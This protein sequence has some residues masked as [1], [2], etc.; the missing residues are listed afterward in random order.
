[1]RNNLGNPIVG[2]FKGPGKTK[3]AHAIKFTRPVVAQYITL[4]IMK[5]S[6]I[7]Q[8]NGIKV[9]EISKMPAVKTGLCHRALKAVNRKMKGVFIPRCNK[10]GSYQKKQ[11]H[12]STGFCWCATSEGKEIAGSRRRGKLDCNKTHTNP[13]GPLPHGPLGPIKPFRPPDKIME[14][15]R[16]IKVYALG[17]LKYTHVNKKKCSTVSK[18]ECLR[19]A[20][21]RRFPVRPIINPRYH[22]FPRGCYH[23]RTT[24][25]IYFNEKPSRKSC[26]TVRV[27]ICKP[28]MYGKG[29]LKPK[30]DMFEDEDDMVDSVH[31]EDEQ[32]DEE[33]F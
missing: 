8:V 22:N 12:G 7:L 33:S 10:D 21:S 19:I 23:K 24:N 26:T 31:D 1:M 20:A 27:C 11:C 30:H 9:T 32:E 14:P 15:V 25:V 3:G 29:L 28:V 16:T 17:N 13:K 6:G 4:Q 2:F 18:A 5:K